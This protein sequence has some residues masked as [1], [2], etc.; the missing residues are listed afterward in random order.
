MTD[1]EIAEQV[2]KLLEQA[3]SVY[4]VLCEVRGR[5]CMWCGKELTPKWPICYCDRY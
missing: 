5:Y 2:L 4:A 1:A 3:E